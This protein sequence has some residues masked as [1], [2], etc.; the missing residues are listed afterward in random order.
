MY[1]PSHLLSSRRGSTIAVRKTSSLSARTQELLASKG[2]LVLPKLPSPLSGSGMMQ[3]Q[4]V[5]ES[6]ETTLNDSPNT[7]AASFAA[8]NDL[9]DS[10]DDRGF[11]DGDGDDLSDGSMVEDTAVDEEDWETSSPSQ[12]HHQ[13]QQS[14]TSQVD[15]SV[16][17]PR[18]QQQSATSQVDTSVHFPRQ[19][20]QSAT[21]RIATSSD[22]LPREQQQFLRQQQQR[23]LNT[24]ATSLDS[25]T[26]LR[27]QQMATNN[28]TPSQ[29][30]LQLLPR[31]SSSLSSTTTTTVRPL[32]SVNN[33]LTNLSPPYSSIPEWEGCNPDAVMKRL[34]SIS[35][36]DLLLIG[37]RDFYKSYICWEKMTVEQRNKTLSWFRSLP[38]HFQGLF[39]FVVYCSAANAY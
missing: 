3:D 17:I 38:E 9:D 18:Q 20:L 29:R 32:L 37:K 26:F 28:N 36:D 5:T 4:D 30:Q 22:T 25:T 8:E 13:Q 14:A 15:T 11:D 24:A 6:Q 39:E 19:Q 10:R 31:N 1:H 33:N 35:K 21:S 7:Y 27:Q 23:V 16:N 12:D 34:K 2:L